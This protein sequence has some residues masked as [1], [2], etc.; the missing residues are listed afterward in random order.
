MAQFLTT[1]G[2]SFEI[3]RTLKTADHQLILISP[4]LKIS[5][6]LLETPT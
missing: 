3:E 2:I 5:A 1:S 6:I 4:Y